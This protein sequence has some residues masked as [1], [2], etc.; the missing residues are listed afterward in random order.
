MLNQAEIKICE[1]FLS[2]QLIDAFQKQGHSMPQPKW[3]GSIKSIGKYLSGGLVFEVTG[4]EY[5]KKYV[6]VKMDAAK[7]SMK[8]FPFMIKY[9]MRRKSLSELEAKPIAAACI[10][11]WMK[12]GRPSKGSYQYSKTGE[13]TGFIEV[14]EKRIQ[15][16][17][18]ELILKY[19]YTD[20]QNYVSTIVKELNSGEK[21]IFTLSV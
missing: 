15:T 9:I 18:G 1:D 16:G 12:E 3:E 7:A 4:A 8:Q 10:K 11:K 13:R 19:K 20:L 2:G 21:I 5:G 14:A 17:F 6:N